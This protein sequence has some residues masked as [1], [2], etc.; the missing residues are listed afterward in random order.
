MKLVH[1]SEEIGLNLCTSQVN[2]LCYCI[3]V[4]R[5]LMFVSSRASVSH[6]FMWGLHKAV[7]YFLIPLSRPDALAVFL[8]IVIS[9]DCMSPIRR[10]TFV[11][12]SDYRTCISIGTV[13]PY[14]LKPT[15]SLPEHYKRNI[16]LKIMQFLSLCSLIILAT[17]THLVGAYNPIGQACD[18]PGASKREY[19]LHI[20]ADL[21]PNRR[22]RVLARR[23]REWR[24]RIHL[25]VRACRH[26]CVHR[27]VRVSYVL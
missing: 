5:T 1:V 17:A 15:S 9:P 14:L 7:F 3:L 26:L 10:C 2:F 11:I 13:C 21:V 4:A 22:R 24:K 6:N 16:T 25:R 18:T 27:R 20:S 12:T 8:A 23:G 19:E